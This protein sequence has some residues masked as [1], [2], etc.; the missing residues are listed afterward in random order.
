M[1]HRA[2]KNWQ[3][4]AKE[5]TYGQAKTQSPQSTQDTVS[6][7]QYSFPFTGMF[8]A[9]P[10]AVENRAVTS[11]TQSGCRKTIFKLEFR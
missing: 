4:T 8:L 7:P 9:L 2:T 3:S 1:T 10:F 5:D 6:V 11:L